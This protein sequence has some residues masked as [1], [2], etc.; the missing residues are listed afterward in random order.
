MSKLKIFLTLKLRIGAE[1][2]RF[3]VAAVPEGK[4][5]FFFKNVKRDTLSFKYIIDVCIS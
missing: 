2:V 4:I 5:S 3:L 1:Y